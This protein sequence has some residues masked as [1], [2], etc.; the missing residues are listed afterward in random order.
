MGCACNTACDPA[1]AEEGFCAIGSPCDG[2]RDC[3]DGT[4]CSATA[5]CRPICSLTDPDVECAPME[6]IERI[7][8]YEAA[9]YKVV[10]GDL[11]ATSLC[12]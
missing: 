7:T 1:T 6:G 8:D 3:P 11:S 2:H 4:L 9:S 5:A 12:S 10:S